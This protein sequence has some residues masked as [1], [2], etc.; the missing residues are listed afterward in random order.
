[1]RPNTGL[2]PYLVFVHG[3]TSMMY[4][5]TSNGALLQL[6]P[7][8]PFDAILARGLLE[9]ATD[10]IVAVM[11]LAGFEAMGISAMPDNLGGAA[12][13]LIV[14]AVLGCGAGFVNA[15]LQTTLRSWDRVWN[16][17]TRLLY[18]FSGIFYVPGMMPDWARD[19]LAWN[20]L[21]HAIDWF[22]TGF[23]ASYEPHWLDRRYLVVSAV[24][25]VLAGLL[26][27]RGLRRHLLSEPA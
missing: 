21:L 2:V 9:F 10:I 4:G 22:R 3:S 16:N 24:L 26:L 11:I 27:E 6:P 5:V 13:A 23:F 7:V 12:T 14:T 19:I 17:V 25:A 8:K 18:F 20:P 15:V 1:M